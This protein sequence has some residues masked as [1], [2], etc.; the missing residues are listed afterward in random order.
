ME[1]GFPPSVVVAII[2][3][4]G[5]I[6]AGGG[7]TVYKIKQLENE[8]QRISGELNTQKQSQENNTELN[9]LTATTSKPEISFPSDKTSSSEQAQ[10]SVTDSTN[11]PVIEK[12]K[13][14]AD[15]IDEWEDHIVIVDC[16]WYSSKDLTL[17]SESYGSGLLIS[18]TNG[19]SFVNTNKHVV[20]EGNSI[21]QDCDIILPKFN[22]TYNVHADWEKMVMPDI[23]TFD[24]FD[25]AQ[26]TI[27][28]PTTIIKNASMGGGKG[29]NVCQE[30]PRIGDDVVVLGYPAIGSRGSI[31]ATEGI[32]S[33]IETGYFVTS[34]KID[35]GNSGG[36]AVLLKNNCYLGIPT[37]SSVGDIESLGRILDY[38]YL[39]INNLYY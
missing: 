9:V 33:G 34:A 36:V 14:L 38:K 8:N 1:R 10:K 22:E 29:I 2:C 19:M 31:T 37:S 18:A 7:Y 32:I 16:R 20:K 39:I 17:L 4:V 35:H 23:A 13:S 11:L 28:N 15:I 25:H 26:I 21:A 30:K 27:T 24:G 12:T 6:M 3:L 5:L